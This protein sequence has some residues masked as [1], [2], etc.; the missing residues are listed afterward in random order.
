MFVH[1]HRGSNHDFQAILDA[2]AQD[3]PRFDAYRWAG[4]ADHGRWPARSIERRSW[5]FA[6]D[7]YIAEGSD[8]RESYTAGPGRIGSNGA[9]SCSSPSGT[10]ELV[11]DTP[12]YGDGVAHEYGADLAAMIDDV[13]RATGAK[14]VDIVAHSMGGLVVRSYLAFNGGSGGSKIERLMLLASPHAGV[15]VVGFAAL[16]GIGPSWMGVHQLAELDSGSPFAKARFV[17]CGDGESSKG[18]WP[19]KLLDVESA[20]PIAA[21]V[22]V[23]SGSR[24]LLIGRDSADH[25]QAKSHVVVEGADHSGILKAP[26]TIARIREVCGGQVR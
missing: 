19:S 11:A 14:K 13:L 23:M 3:D 6:F 8:A 25:P 20:A 15:G 26:A 7:Y 12:A 17:R 18:S 22:H 1:G 10:G 2:L 4:V 16:F 24:D 9:R 5:L 21:E